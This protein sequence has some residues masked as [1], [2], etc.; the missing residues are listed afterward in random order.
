MW[1]F[2]CGQNGPLSCDSRFD[3]GADA[4]ILRSLKL[5]QILVQ[6]MHRQ[7]PTA[8]AA[9][10]VSQPVI[11]SRLSGFVFAGQ[12]VQGAGG[13]GH[14]CLRSVVCFDG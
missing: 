14:V 11:A 2:Q 1:V 8:A 7:D 4:C 3:P 12:G 13:V 10:L 9:D 5:L 6:A